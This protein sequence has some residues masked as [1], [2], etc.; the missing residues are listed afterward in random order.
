MAVS[1]AVSWSSSA[2]ATAVVIVVAAMVVVVVVVKQQQQF[3]V[4]SMLDND[5]GLGYFNKCKLKSSFLIGL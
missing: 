5:V 2:P 1:A 4:R 3:L